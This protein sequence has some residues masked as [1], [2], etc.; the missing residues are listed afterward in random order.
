MKRPAGLR[1]TKIGVRAQTASKS[2]MERGTSASRAMASRWSTSLVEP[3]VAATLAMALSKAARVQ[4]SRGR[5]LLR[6]AFIM[7]WPQR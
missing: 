7:I 1:S 2:S 6:T 5:R 4:M 3:P